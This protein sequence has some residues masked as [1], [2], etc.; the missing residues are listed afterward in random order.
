MKERERERERGKKEVSF[1]T[2]PFRVFDKRD[3]E[4]HREKKKKKKV[5]KTSSL[6]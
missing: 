4:K 6:P 1:F 5:P 2:K 3:L